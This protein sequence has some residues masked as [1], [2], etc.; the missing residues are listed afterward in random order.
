MQADFTRTPLG[1]LELLAGLRA[2]STNY[3]SSRIADTT[4]YFGLAGKHFRHLQVCF[5]ADYPAEL[6]IALVLPTFTTSAQMPR[7]TCI[8]TWTCNQHTSQS[9]NTKTCDSLSRRDP[10]WEAMELVHVEHSNLD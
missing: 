7:A 2:Y 4:F 10:T 9:D 8:I 3:H 1:V 6:P 5:I